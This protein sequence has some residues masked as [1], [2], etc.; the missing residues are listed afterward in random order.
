MGADEQ[1]G[2]Y[3]LIDDMVK[4]AYLAAAAACKRC[5]YGLSPADKK[6]SA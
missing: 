4:R 3:A 2:A 5:V 6:L 1:K